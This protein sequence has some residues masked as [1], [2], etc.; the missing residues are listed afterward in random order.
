MRR[1]LQHDRF[2][3]EADVPALEALLA[4]HDETD[5]G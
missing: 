4:E 3:F 1:G 5:S 2:E